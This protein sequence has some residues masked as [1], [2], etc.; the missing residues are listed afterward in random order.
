VLN[1]KSHVCLELL[2]KLKQNWITNAKRSDI[3]Q[4]KGQADRVLHIIFSILE[5]FSL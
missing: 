5:I 1:P 2:S 3:I 4:T